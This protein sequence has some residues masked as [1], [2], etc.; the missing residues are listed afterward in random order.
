MKWLTETISRYIEPARMLPLN[1]KTL[2][3]VYSTLKELYLCRDYASMNPSVVCIDVSDVCNLSCAICSREINRDKRHNNFMSLPEFQEAYNQT[4]PYYL[5]ISGYG[6]TLLNKDVCSMIEYGVKKGSSVMIVTNGMLLDKS[7]VENLISAGT[8]KIKISMDAAEPEAYEKYRKGA[9][10]ERVVGNIEYLLEV[11]RKKSLVKPLVE[12]QFTL[13]KDNPDQIEKMIELCHKRLKGI[14][15]FFQLMFTYGGQKE[16]A[17]LSISTGDIRGIEVLDKAMD[18]AICRGFHRSAGALHQI[19]RQL[20]C[21]LSNA[22]CYQPWYFSLIS[23]DGDVYPCCHHSIHGNSLGNVFKEGFKEIWNGEKMQSFRRLL[24]KRRCDN[25]V[26]AL[27]RYEER[28]MEKALT[29]VSK[30][31]GLG[32]IK[33]MKNSD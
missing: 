5:Q 2:M 6:E 3:I 31:P 16:F 26:C 1:P 23:T 14:Q 15:P 22:V 24:K 17:D 25:K 13:F 8:A 18:T 7:M 10:F 20:T 21:D 11:K 12:V 33:G 28:A 29:V 9:D 4:H 30:I 27:C 32:K 19:R